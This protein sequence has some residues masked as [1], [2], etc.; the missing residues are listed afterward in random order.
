MPQKDA[1]IFE[2]HDAGKTNYYGILFLVIIGAPIIFFICLFLQGPIIFA[3][4]MSSI[5]VTILSIL[6][7]LTFS[8]GKM[9]YEM[10]AKDCIIR[11]GV[12][13]KHFSYSKIAEAEI[14][15]LSLKIRL[16]GASLPG[17][18]WGLFKTSIGNAHVYATKID[19]DFIL[20]T[21]NDNEKIVLSPKKSEAFLN[22]LKE[23]TTIST[24][25]KPEAMAQ[26]KSY[27]KRFVYAQV[28][29]VTAAFL[30]FLTY[31]IH[32]YTILPEIVPVHFGFNGEANRWAN[33]S[34][35]FL[36][37]GIAAIFPTINAI[38]TIKFGKY[39]KKLVIFLG[40]V[41]V[42]IAILFMYVLNMIA[43]AA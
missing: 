4:S 21:L 17:F 31:F 28:V 27:N 33:K 38:L 24:T 16:F 14:V 39:E 26:E 13:K 11:F 42:A 6:A 35:L 43:M 22:L 12:F 15:N 7:Y 3:V 30:V 8:G 29:I 9:K 36:L 18:H 32:I 10:S 19:G 20:L 37:L 1:V 2:P 34:E 41:F 40:A 25:Q 5:M 23:R